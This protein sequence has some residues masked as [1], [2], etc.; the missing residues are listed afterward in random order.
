MNLS[1]T[2]PQLPNVLVTLSSWRWFLATTILMLH[3]PPFR[4]RYFKV[5]SQGG[6]GAASKASDPAAR[7]FKRKYVPSASSESRA[8]ETMVSAPH[9]HYVVPKSKSRSRRPSLSY[10]HSSG[11]STQKPSRSETI[12]QAELRISHY[13]ASVLDNPPQRLQL[14]S[15]ASERLTFHQF[16]AR[17]SIHH[18]QSSWDNPIPFSCVE[19]GQ[20]EHHG[21]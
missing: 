7:S 4:D 9:P 8:R 12:E 16:R 15:Q 11:I 3:K 13:L 10:V 6:G 17:S 1:R 5:C 20:R 18:F 14:E 2:H 21:A 19:T